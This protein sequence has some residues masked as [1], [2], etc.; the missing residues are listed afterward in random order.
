[1]LNDQVSDQL[2]IG[3]MGRAMILKTL[4]PIPLPN[5]PLPSLLCLSSVVTLLQLCGAVLLA[6]SQPVRSRK[7]N[8]SL[9]LRF[10]NAVLASVSI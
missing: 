4:L 10:R 5:I 6:S 7:S 3:M 1:M 2:G 9:T 8:C